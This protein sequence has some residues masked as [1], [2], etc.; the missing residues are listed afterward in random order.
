MDCSGT[1]LIRNTH[2]PRI[3]IGPLAKGYCRV[4]RGGGLLMSEVPL[5][6][7]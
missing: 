4:L 6:G 2:P 7:T 5:W 3:S 1:L